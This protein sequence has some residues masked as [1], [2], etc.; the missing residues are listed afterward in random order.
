[1]KELYITAID[2]NK[3]KHSINKNIITP[4][5]SKNIQGGRS[6]A[7]SYTITNT[8]ID[9]FSEAINIVVNIVDETVRV[10]AIDVLN[11]IARYLQN[12]N[13]APRNFRKLSAVQNED[14]S[15]LI[16]WHYEKFHI[17][18]SLEP[19]ENDSYYFMVSI[20]ESINSIDSKTR[21]INGEIDII[22]N[23]IV[24]F[25]INNA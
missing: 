22:I 9:I 20:D 14:G 24:Q 21:R 6:V 12:L 10:Q 7:H 19:N 3:N 23:D 13:T 16:E 11:K 4:S 18:L 17:G 15:C 8:L 5:M 25:V 2:V 1:M